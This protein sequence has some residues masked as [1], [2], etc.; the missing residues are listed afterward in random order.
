MGGGG[1]AS[2][3]RVAPAS[4]G[5]VAVRKGLLKWRPLLMAVPPRVPLLL[6]AWGG[7]VALQGGV[8]LSPS[9]ALGTLRAW[10]LGSGA[11]SPRAPGEWE[12]HPGCCSPRPA[13]SAL[14]C[15]GRSPARC[16]WADPCWAAWA[17]GVGT[18]GGLD[19]RLT[20]QSPRA[21]GWNT[22]VTPATLQFWAGL[23]AAQAAPV[24]LCPSSRGPGNLVL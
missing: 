8:A 4:G 20:A 14:T 16:A 9:W 5:R 3:P 6:D 2:R 22:P 17:L 7:A 24:S 21:P 13:A 15:P 11:S 23:L 19:P 12:Q 1:A 10:P 18:G